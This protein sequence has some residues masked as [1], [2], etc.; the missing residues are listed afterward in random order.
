MYVCF[1]SRRK[2]LKSRK[3]KNT[4]HAKLRGCS[5]A[6]QRDHRRHLLSR[7]DVNRT[8]FQEMAAFTR[9]DSVKILLLI[10]ESFL[11]A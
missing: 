1:G 3:G 7:A 2:S 11:S 8:C 9:L 6:D 5:I 10:I 4:A